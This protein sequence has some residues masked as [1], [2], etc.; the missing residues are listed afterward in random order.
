VGARHDLAFLEVAEGDKQR[1]DADND[2]DNVLDGA[3]LA[4]C[5]V[6]R[7]L[8]GEMDVLKTSRAWKV[9]EC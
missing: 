5:G 1:V 7:Q 6:H 4:C 8:P 9:D 2:V 3:Y